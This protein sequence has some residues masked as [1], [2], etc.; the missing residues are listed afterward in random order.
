MLPAARVVAA[1]AQAFLGHLLRGEIV[2]ASGEIIARFDRSR[3]RSVSEIPSF[4]K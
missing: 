1:G 4:S 3:T 2:A